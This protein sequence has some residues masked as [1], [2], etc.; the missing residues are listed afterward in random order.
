MNLYAENILDHYRH[1]RGKSAMQ[2]SK[3]KIHHTESNPSCGD[4]IT[5]GLTIEGRTIKKIGWEG[6]GCA[7]SQAA[8][9]M[10]FEELEGKTIDDIE[11]L[12][13]KDV[14]ELLGVPIST[15]RMNCALLCLQGMRKALRN[16][17]L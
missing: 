13:N 3:F 11:K 2:N 16:N 1:P 8:M 15:R 6:T 4:E 5:I 9:S 12:S 10:L 14:L 17:T 7:I